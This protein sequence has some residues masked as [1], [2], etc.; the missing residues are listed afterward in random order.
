MSTT[1]QRNYT[2]WLKEASDEETLRRA[3][4]H[5]RAIHWAAY[6]SG[7]DRGVQQHVG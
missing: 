3:S 5:L 1:T 6:G 2:S 7:S 4:S